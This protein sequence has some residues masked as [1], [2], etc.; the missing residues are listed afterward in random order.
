MMTRTL[1]A[2][3]FLLI[4]G[5]FL[6]ASSASADDYTWNFRN[7]HF[8]NLSLVPI[9]PGAVN[10]LRPTND[11]LRISVPAGHD[12]K[13]VGFSPRFKVRGD[14]EMTVEFTILN[15]TQ[16]QSGSGTGPNIYLSMGSTKDPAAALGRQLRP[17]GRDI[18]GVF[19]ARVDA[20]QRIPKAK[21]F[22]VPNPAATTSGSLRLQ[23]IKQ[24][25]T[26]AVSDKSQ[27][28]FRSL[29]TLD[30][31]DADVTMLRVGLSQSDPQSAAEILIHNIHITATALP[32]LPSAES[33][34][35]QLYRPRYQP[36]PTPKSYRWLWQ[37]V[38]GLIVLGACAAWLWRRRR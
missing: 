22:D 4:V 25:I 19:A 16:P 3:Q 11:G 6:A 15:R 38:A 5:C 31:S 7:G 37:S 8:D 26:Y 35:A 10:L 24:Q 14:F 1:A 18:Y 34:T 28:M 27:P 29:A 30:V 32:E 20:G 12:V 17:D 21:L 36:P 23:R 33:R 13:S 2:M 9:G